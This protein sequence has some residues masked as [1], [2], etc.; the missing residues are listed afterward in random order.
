MESASL[1]CSFVQLLPQ[2]AQLLR[3]LGQLRGRD[4]RPLQRTCHKL[5]QRLRLREQGVCV[6]LFLRS[7][8]SELLLRNAQTVGAVLRLGLGFQ[9][10]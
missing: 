1:H 10:G 5:L 7:V 8:L 6:A 4:A 9:P 3:H 2:A